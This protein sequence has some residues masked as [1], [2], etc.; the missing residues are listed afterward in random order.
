MGGIFNTCSCGRGRKEGGGSLYADVIVLAKVVVV[1]AAAVVVVVAV[2]VV[3]RGSSIGPTP[4]A[5]SPHDD[6][7]SIQC[8]EGTKT[9][10]LHLPPPGKY[11][12]AKIFN[13]TEI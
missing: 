8:A 4:F 10:V 7:A 12:L 11:Y 6:L 2:V 9:S 1:V 3:T 13:C 5:N